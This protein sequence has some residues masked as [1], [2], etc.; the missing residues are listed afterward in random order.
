MRPLYFRVKQGIFSSLL[1][2]Y[3]LPYKR[4]SRGNNT[5]I[6]VRIKRVY[7]YIFHVKEVKGILYPIITREGY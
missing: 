2:F 1:R 5:S 7:K 6:Y 4:Y 3:Y